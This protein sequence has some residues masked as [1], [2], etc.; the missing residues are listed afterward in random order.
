MSCSVLSQ[1]CA[2]GFS[3]LIAG[4]YAEDQGVVAEKCNPYTGKVL[5]ELALSENGLLRHYAMSQPSTEVL[6][7]TDTRHDGF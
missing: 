2:G 7:D 5:T 3:Y 4:R 6:W 1:G